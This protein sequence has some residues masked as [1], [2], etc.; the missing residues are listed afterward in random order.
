MIALLREIHKGHFTGDYTILRRPD[1][2]DSAMH[3]AEA[4][5]QRVAEHTRS[6]REYRNTFLPIGQLPV[7]ILAEVFQFCP[8]QEDELAIQRSRPQNWLGFSQV[9][10]RWRGIA[11]DDAAIWATP[12]SSTPQLAL[13]M[14]S[15]AKNYPL[16]ISVECQT[17]KRRFRVAKAALAKH[18]SLKRL[19]L[20]TNPQQL[21]ELVKHVD[22]AMPL[23]ETIDINTNPASQIPWA[24]FAEFE[25]PC[26]WL[27]RL[28][29]CVLPWNSPCLR[30]LTFL[31]ISA[32]C[33]GDSFRSNGP[34]ILA[35]LESMTALQDLFLTDVVCLTTPVT[36]PSRRVTLGNL[37]QLVLFDDIPHLVWF[38]RHCSLPVLEVLLAR[39]REE[40]SSLDAPMQLFECIKDWLVSDLPCGDIHTLYTRAVTDPDSLDARLELCIDLK[41]GGDL[42]CEPPLVVCLNL[43]FSILE[44]ASD[45]IARIF[46][47]NRLSGLRMEV[48]HDMPLHSLWTRMSSLSLVERLWLSAHAVEPFAGIF[49]ADMNEDDPGPVMPFPNLKHLTIFDCRMTGVCYPPGM[50]A[51]RRL[52]RVLRHL[53]DRGRLPETVSFYNCKSLTEPALVFEK[54]GIKGSVKLKVFRHRLSLKSH[55]SN[56]VRA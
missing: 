6:L 19:R 24:R 33:T 14:I 38:F 12:V 22:H 23:L 55:D 16:S 52:A 35:A 25:T 44:A 47:F 56:P 37:H 3:D 34:D 32:G 13:L 50:T 18:A 11:L 29:G 36:L 20:E 1:D 51:L 46:D 8:P 17:D 31:E 28:V 42:Q 7:E 2:V 48:D 41:A 10:R 54:F 4:I 40:E 15:R 21:A 49:E 45:Y 5:I 27:V 39:G 53:K 26:L 30:N 43:D 9:C